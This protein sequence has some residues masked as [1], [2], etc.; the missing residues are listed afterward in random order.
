MLSVKG[1]AAQN[2]TNPLSPYSFERKEPGENDILIDIL[3][4]GVCHSDLHFAKNEWGMTVFPVVPG[5]EI[6]AA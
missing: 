2:E 3:Y 1:F 6:I 4:C 5:H